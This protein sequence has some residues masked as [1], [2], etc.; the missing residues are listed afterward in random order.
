[1]III[2]QNTRYIYSLNFC[3]CILQKN[4]EKEIIHYSIFIEKYGSIQVKNDHTD[5]F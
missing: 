5:L 2:T 4:G 3:I 1:M